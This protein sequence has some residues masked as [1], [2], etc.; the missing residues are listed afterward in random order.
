MQYLKYYSFSFITALLL[1]TS[2]NNYAKEL[3]A[4]I[5]YN[6]P[7][8]ATGAVRR[9]GAGIRSAGKLV[10]NVLAPIHVGQVM[11]EQPRLYWASNVKVPKAR[12]SLT[13]NPFGKA[14][15][16]ANKTVSAQD[17]GIHSVAL[18]DL[19]YK[20]KPG[21]LYQ[22]TISADKML[23]SAV[24]KLVKPSA[25]VLNKITQANQTQLPSVYAAEG[26][27]YDAIDSLSQLIADEPHNVTYKAARRS[28]LEQV[29]LK[30]VAKLD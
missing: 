28:L 20:L 14:Q 22:F 24:I 16:V 13:E 23:A 21:V 3:L 30:Q 6:P 15:V 1:F 12:F 19:D 29:D 26:L 5:V 9:S 4:N 8:E 18:A 10:L 2:A 17:A 25:G 11:H 7:E 27:W